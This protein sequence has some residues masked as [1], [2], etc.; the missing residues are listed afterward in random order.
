MVD[1]AYMVEEKQTTNYTKKLS[2]MRFAF[3]LKHFTHTLLCRKKQHRQ[4]LVHSIIKDAV[5]ILGFGCLF[6]DF[7]SLNLKEPVSSAASHLI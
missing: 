3:Q 2:C 4:L 1:I 7:L 6:K 5:L